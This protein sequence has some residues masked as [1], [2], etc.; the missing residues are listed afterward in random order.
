MTTT[1]VTWTN[2]QGDQF[3]TRVL[4]H[5]LTPFSADVEDIG[6]TVLES[7]VEGTS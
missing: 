1:M 2:A 6:G 7:H 5:H 3:T 4:T